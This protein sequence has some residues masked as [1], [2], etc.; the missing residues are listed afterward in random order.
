M[1]EE[2]LGYF[3]EYKKSYWLIIIKKILLSMNISDEIMMLK[4]CICEFLNKLLPTIK[5]PC[6]LTR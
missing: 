6:I 5:D 1:I 3:E 4:K 2:F